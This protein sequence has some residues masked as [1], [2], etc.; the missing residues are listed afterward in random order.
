[1]DFWAS[2]KP[3][4]KCIMHLHDRLSWANEWYTSL[5]IK[6]LPVNWMHTPT[7]ILAVAKIASS[8]LI[9]ISTEDKTVR[10][11]EM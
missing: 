2:V 1:M 4:I 9:N 6:H 5:S 3:K 10:M 11:V 8:L 7:I